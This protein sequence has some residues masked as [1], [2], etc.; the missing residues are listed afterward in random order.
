MY[1]LNL[2][3]GVFY[4]GTTL[5]SEKKFFT[6]VIYP[7]QTIMVYSLISTPAS[8]HYKERREKKELSSS[9]SHLGKEHVSF[10]LVT[11]V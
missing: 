1:E 7:T 9:V 3:K 8:S 11:R 2:G 6:H 4:C 10:P 5:K